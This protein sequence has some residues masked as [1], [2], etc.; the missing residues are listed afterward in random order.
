MID[1]SERAAA[2]RRRDRWMF[3]AV[4]LTAVLILAIKIV[5]AGLVYDDWSCAFS[6]CVK[7][8]S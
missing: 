4:I 7:I 5:H 1:Y 3:F 8:K 6:R 2:A